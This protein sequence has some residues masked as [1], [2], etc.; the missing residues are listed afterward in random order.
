MEAFWSLSISGLY[1]LS[2]HGDTDY[3]HTA[4]SGDSWPS[5]DRNWPNLCVA[6]CGG[7]IRTNAESAV[8]FP[9]GDV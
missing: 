8:E 9:K 3:I 5:K 4:I 2:Y 7:N 6:H 1:L